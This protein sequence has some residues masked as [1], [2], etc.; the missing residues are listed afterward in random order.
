MFHYPSYIRIYEKY[1]GNWFVHI[2]KKFYSES[3][4]SLEKGKL[5]RRYGL[6]L[7]RVI[8]RL[9]LL[10]EG[11]PGYYVVDLKNK[12]Y[13]YCG[14]QEEGVRDTLVQ[15]GFHCNSLEAVDG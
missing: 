8:S 12:Q 15:M 4:I 11:Q 6:T 14:T 13:H 3:N 9:S 10:F 7:G 5:E 2:G 1:Q